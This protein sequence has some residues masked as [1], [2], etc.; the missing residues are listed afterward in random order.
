MRKTNLKS[1]IVHIVEVEDAKIEEND[2]NVQPV[3]AEVVLV[4]EVD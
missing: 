3:E 2:Q 4:V 1:E